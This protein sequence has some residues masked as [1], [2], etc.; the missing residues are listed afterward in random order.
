MVLREKHFASLKKL[1]NAEFTNITMYQLMILPGTELGLDDSK[2]R[3][4]MHT[5]YRVLP[6]CY[7]TYEILGKKISVAEIEEVGISNNTLSFEDYLECRKMNLVIQI[8]FNDGIFEEILFLIY[9]Y[10]RSS[11]YVMILSY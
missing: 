6:R 3:Y 10:K 1:V 11:L 5:K 7:G 8:F 9:W 2:S 4:K